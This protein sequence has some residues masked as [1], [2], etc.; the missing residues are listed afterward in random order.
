MMRKAYIFRRV[1]WTSLRITGLALFFGPAFFPTVDAQA[2]DGSAEL[3]AKT[4]SLIEQFVEK[5]AYLRYEEDLVQ[6][7][8]KGNQKVDYSQETVFDSITRMNFEEGKLRVDE[9]RLIEKSPA[10]VDAR[11]LLSTNGFSTLAM[12]FHPYFGTSFNFTRLADDTLGGKLLA[13]IHFEH[14]PA[15]PSPI[16]YQVINA[17]RPLD[18]SGTAWVD[19]STGEIYRIEAGT[20]AALGDMG[21]KEIRA[22]VLYGSVVLRD[23]TQPQWLPVMATVDLETPRQHWRNIHRFQDYRKYRVAV[24]L[25]GAYSQ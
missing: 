4:Q 8:L 23:E 24:N 12:I 14:I 19:P 15:K 17:D 16:L 25:P 1:L 20:G 6:Q 13:R 11:P 7:K 21:L 18:L 5:F 9:Q 3:L 10:R 2:A 22:Q